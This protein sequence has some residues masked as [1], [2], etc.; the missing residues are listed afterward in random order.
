MTI[1]SHE[2]YLLTLRPRVYCRCLGRFRHLF[3]TYTQKILYA[4]CGL[5]TFKDKAK[6]FF[7]KYEFSLFFFLSFLVLFQHDSLYI[8]KSA[9]N[10]LRRV[11]NQFV[12]KGKYW[13]NMKEMHAKF[14]LIFKENWCST[15]AIHAWKSTTSLKRYPCNFMKIC[16]SIKEILHTRSYH[17]NTNANENNVKVTKI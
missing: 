12:S 16:Q 4:R 14:R 6:M 13:E 10:I 7:G 1:I 8:K 3:F 11:F 5:I 17:I 2:A 15:P 9:S